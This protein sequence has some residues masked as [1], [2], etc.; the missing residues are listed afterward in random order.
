MHN[1][2]PLLERIRQ[3]QQQGESGVLSLARDDKSIRIYFNQGLI[4]A[5]SADHH[6]QRL[7]QY[8]VQSGFVRSGEIDSLVAESKRKRISLG[9][10]AVRRK[11]IDPAELAAAIRLQAYQLLKEAFEKNPSVREF[12]SNTHSFYLPARINPEHLL[13]ELART[14]PQPFEVIPDY[15]IMLSNGHQLSHLAWYPEELSVLGALKYPKTLQNLAGVTGL[16]Y[17]SLSKILNVL[18]TLKLVEVVEAIPRA[19]AAD[20]TTDLRTD[21]FPFEHL[22]PEVQSMA[23]SQKLEVL[24]KES[25]FISEQFKTLK[26]RISEFKP[27]QP[28]KVIAVSSPH[29]GDGKSLVSVNLALS[30]SKDSGHRVILVDCDMR[31]PSLN[32]YLGIS[33]EPGLIG[34][35]ENRH[36]QPQCYVRRLERL[37]IMTAGGTTANPVELLSLDRMRGLIDYLKTEFDVII[38]D[39]PALVPISDARILNGF[40]DGHLM[41]VR[42]G[43]TPCRLIGHALKVLDPQKFIG[44]VFNDVKPMW[45]HTQY[46]Y[47]YYHYP[48]HSLNASDGRRPRRRP[49]TYLEQ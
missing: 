15:P 19:N 4:D 49:K 44:V 23:C 6:D 21:R 48:Y 35:L 16:E 10:A 13:L 32:K 39:T 30:F 40:A 34:Y 37:Y 42:R 20:E 11:I 27:E 46:G 8:L 24:H 12:E 22:T 7:G 43:K 38:L 5:V 29:P 17:A 26:V 45:F 2:Q 36:L 1:K 33:P 18:H 28:V 41:I 9:E 3:Y 25:S 31:N 14:N 47:R